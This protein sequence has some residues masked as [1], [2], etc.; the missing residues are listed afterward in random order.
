MPVNAWVMGKGEEE[1][2]DQRKGGQERIPMPGSRL[3][4]GSFTIRDVGCE[5]LNKDRGDSELV[6]SSHGRK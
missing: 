3:S 4:H 5:G 2:G 1:A 6:L